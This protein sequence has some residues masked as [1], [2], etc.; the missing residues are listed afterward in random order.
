MSTS[1]SAEDLP[2]SNNPRKSGLALMLDDGTRKSHSVAQNTA[3]VTGFFK[4]L[5][6]KDSYKKLLTSLYF[7]YKEMEESID[8]TDEHGVKKLDD[9]K[10]LRRVESL[11]R[12]LDYFYGGANLSDITASPKT[13]NYVAHIRK[14]AKEKPY[15]LIAHQYTRYLGDLFGGQM[16]SGMASKS[17]GLD[18]GEGTDFYSFE[19]IDNVQQYITEWYNTLNSLELSDK[20]KDEIVDEAN[21]VF[22]FNIDILEELDGNAF[23]AMWML[24]LNSIKE[25]FTN[26]EKKVQLN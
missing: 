25:K 7:V 26:L 16:M 5:S 14:V 4:G 21:L 8:I 20:Q 9:P 2:E 22:D 10:K 17:L 23:N 13:L 6:N 12:D 24:L 18:E 1:P 19:K 11:E 3:F 15:L